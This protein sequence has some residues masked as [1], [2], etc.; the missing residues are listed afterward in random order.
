MF[1]QEPSLNLIVPLMA[2]GMMCDFLA[3]QPRS[4]LIRQIRFG[5]LTSIEVIALVCGVSVALI[6]AVLNCGYW[7]LVLQFIVSQGVRCIGYWLSCRWRPSKP[8][9]IWKL[10]NQINSMFSYGVNLSIFHI[11]NR[12]SMEMD[13]ILVGAINGATALGFYTQ[14]YNWAYFPFNQ[15]YLP[16]VSIANSSLI[17]AAVEADWYRRQTQEVL[18]LMFNLLLPILGFLMVSGEALMLILLGEQWL[19]AFSIFQVLLLLV[20]VNSFYRV[21]KWIYVSSGQTQ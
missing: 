3:V 20:F 6:A 7:A 16:L 4:L 19:D 2:L 8:D 5:V 13:R 15:I 18:M 17:R 11:I 21:T 14:A 9:N 10:R 1:Y 12:I